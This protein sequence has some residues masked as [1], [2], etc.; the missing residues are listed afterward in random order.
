MAG[1]SSLAVLASQAPDVSRL[2]CPM[3]DARNKELYC[4]TYR[5][6]NGDLMPVAAERAL[7]PEACASSITE[8]CLLIG[9]GAYRYRSFFESR[10]GD[11]A[12][13]ATVS[14]GIP[15]ALTVARLGLNRVSDPPNRL[16]P[17]CGSRIPS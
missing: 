4:A 14:D 10:I 1:V 17:D 7:S 9:D 16:R 3:M 13:F 2:I 6:K 5:L 8:P 11:D 15:R 12:R